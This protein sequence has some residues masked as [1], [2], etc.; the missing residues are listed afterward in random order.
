MFDILSLGINIQELVSPVFDKFTKPGFAPLLATG[1][2][3]GAI[4]YSLWIYFRY[5]RQGKKSIYKARK[6]FLTIQT[7]E[8]FSNA[9][10]EIKEVMNDIPLLKHGWSEFSETLIPPD[11]KITIF[12]NT[13]RP[14]YYLN[15]N[16][17][18]H[19]IGLKKIHFISNIF[20]GIGLLLT[21]VGLVAALTKAGAAI[22]MKG[23]DFQKPIQ[24]LL[25]VAAFKFWTSIAGLGCSIGL[26]WFY[27]IQHNKIKNLLYQINNGIERGLQ[28]VTPEYLSIEHLH[29][30]REQ[31]SA[32]KQFSQTLAIELADKIQAGFSSALSP[33]QDSLKDLGNR[34]TSGIG[35]AVKGAAGTE[36]DALSKNLGDIVESLNVTRLEM[37]GVGAVFRNNMADAA[38]VLRTASGE[39]S[40]EMS[41]QLQDIMQTVAEENRKQSILF[42]ESIKRMSGAVNQAS[43]SAGGE[44]TKAAENLAI[45]INGV[46][47]GVKASAGAMTDAASALRTASSEASNEM[48]MQLRNVMLTLAEESGKQSLKFDETMK[49]LSSVMGQASQTAG[50]KITN[51]A[52]NLAIGM[53]GVS[54]GVRDSAGLMAEQMN[55]LS[56][57]LQTIE[58][59]M[60]NHVKAMDNLTNKAQDTEKA[61]GA[62]S[63]YLSDATLP[64]TQA[65]NRM[66]TTAEQ[67]N[68]SIQGV[69]LIITESYQNIKILS[70]KMTET[71]QALQTAWQSY[72]K[73]FAGVDESLGKA[74]QGIVDNVRDNI[75]SLGTFVQKIDSELGKSVQI[76]SQNIGEL[77]ET[78]ESFEEATSKL[79]KATDTIADKII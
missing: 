51:A 8:D 55:N 65:T 38:S 5:I 34:I 73:R 23:T 13:V 48:L 47:D 6:L 30:A 22:G 26:R 45:G 21:F 44:I 3:S 75:Q 74:L 10:S 35:D 58:D 53:N 54:D 60:N 20:V 56:T 33:V 40:K 52:E 36:M 11:G 9:Y 69:S 29:E 72:D 39:S 71:Q 57:V 59:K 19:S 4:L 17:V 14:S 61:M 77:N 7:Q 18:E 49:Q 27:E 76:F 16:E 32:M 78:A 2:V 41:K 67:L 24:D 43:E 62:T 1:M 15:A 79:L 42:D 70:G 37:D 31:S 66:A 68:L 46:S 28:L 12:R 63:R 50:T 25:S 64:V